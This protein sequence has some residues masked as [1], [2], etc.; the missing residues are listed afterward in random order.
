MCISQ[1]CTHTNTYTR[2]LPCEASYFAAGYIHVDWM[3]LCLP[4]LCLPLSLL[5]VQAAETNSKCTHVHCTH[6]L[7]DTG[8]PSLL[9]FN[10]CCQLLCLPLLFLSQVL[11]QRRRVELLVIPATRTHTS[12]RNVHA[13][14]RCT[15]ELQTRPL[16]I[17][18]WTQSRC[19]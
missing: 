12:S 15:P 5:Q 10:L 18:R 11:G 19:L 17:N 2:S 1:S 7:A 3:L 6:V 9:R 13:C 16:L 14:M 8:A 4:L